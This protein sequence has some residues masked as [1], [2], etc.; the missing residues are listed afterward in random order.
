MFRFILRILFLSGYKESSILV[1][2]NRIG[3]CSRCVQ[4]WWDPRKWSGEIS[5]KNTKL[6][7]TTQSLESALVGVVYDTPEGRWRRTTYFIDS[8]ESN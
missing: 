3:F 8:L 7:I 4:Y 6:I 1:R 5:Q 2:H